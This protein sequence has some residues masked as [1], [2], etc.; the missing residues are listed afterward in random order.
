MCRTSYTVEVTGLFEPCSI[1]AYTDWGAEKKKEVFKCR[2]HTGFDIFGLF[3][4]GKKTGGTKIKRIKKK[5][6]FPL[7]SI[8]FFVN[9][10]K[11]FR[12]L[13]LSV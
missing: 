7:F 6:G 9:R 2:V 10:I 8:D 5:K 11:F 3:L 1:E 13:D 12:T 4:H